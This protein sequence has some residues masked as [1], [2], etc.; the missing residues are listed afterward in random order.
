MQ[1]YNNEGQMKKQYYPAVRAGAPAVLQPT[2]TYEFLYDS[3]ARLNQIKE[4]NPQ[5]NY[6]HVNSIVWS[7]EPD[8]GDWF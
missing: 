5:Q 3:M 8:D 2:P 6:F 1:E 4:T 7:G